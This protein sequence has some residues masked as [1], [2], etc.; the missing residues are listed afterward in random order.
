[1][2]SLGVLQQ[3]LQLISLGLGQGRWRLTIVD[4]AGIRPALI[5]ARDRNTQVTGYVRVRLQ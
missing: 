2:A 3:R 1:M 4:L 5:D